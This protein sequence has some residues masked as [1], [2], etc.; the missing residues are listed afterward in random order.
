MNERNQDAPATRGVRI[1][2]FV[3]A[4]RWIPTLATVLMAT[5]LFNLGLWQLDRAHTK[6]YMEERLRL[7]SQETPHDLHS[8]LREGDDLSDFPVRLRGHFLNEFNFLLDNRTHR[9]QPG[10]EVITPFVTDD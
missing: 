10:Y 8:L 6:E 2:Q 1:G 4:P 9:Q 3:F 7:R 5:L